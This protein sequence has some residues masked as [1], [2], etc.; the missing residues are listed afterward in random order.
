MEFEYLEKARKETIKRN[1]RFGRA[2]KERMYL[3]SYTTNSFED[4]E[5]NVEGTRGTN[6]NVT[7]NTR[8]MNCNCPYTSRFHKSC[9][10]MFF[11]IGRICKL[12]L[13]KMTSDRYQINAF[14][15][16]PELNNSLLKTLTERRNKINETET[17]TKTETEAEEIKPNEIDDDC[18]I[19]F[20]EMKIGKLEKCG[21][22]CN[23]FH[24]ECLVRW[25]KS[26]SNC[27]LCR[28]VIKLPKNEIDENEII[29][30]M[31]KLIF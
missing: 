3:L 25:L 14:K 26:K 17:G 29:D 8:G 5:F 9:K 18:S 6:Y 28:S 13:E 20:E 15:L 22:C 23:H 24:S 19:C 1:E 27:P 21:T 7:F 31:S 10:H 4:W 30:V 16:Y 2:L 12:P 11:I